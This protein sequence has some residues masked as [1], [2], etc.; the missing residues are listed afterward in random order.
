MHLSP[1]AT[2]DGPSASLS[3]YSQ[4]INPRKTKLVDDHGVGDSL[5]D[6]G[7]GNGLYVLATA[8]KYSRVLQIDIADRRL[9]E[10]R[11]QP[12][13]LIDAKDIASLGSTFDTVLCFDILEHLDDDVAFADAVRRLCTG[14]II[15]SVPA[16]DD[17]RLR[18][19]GLTHLHHV[20]KTHRREYTQESLHL[21][22]GGAGFVDIRIFPQYNDGII[23]AARALRTSSLL[24]RLS[25]KAFEVC[26]RLLCRMG[27]FRNES[28]ADWLFVA[29]AVRDESCHPPPA[30][31]QTS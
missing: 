12:F 11:H 13:L 26:T 29:R 27:I 7:C 24:S 14:C 2:C 23:L 17:E 3:H 28:V 4:N 25:A 9:A 18:S 10:A 15:G 30:S 5:L 6:V 21:L 20:D 19:I 31:G 1:S 16:A 22:L 8:R